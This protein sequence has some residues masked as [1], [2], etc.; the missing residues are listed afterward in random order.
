MLDEIADLLVGSRCPGCRE[1]GLG[2]CR[3]CREGLPARPRLVSGPLP[4]AAAGD[5]GPLERA[6]VT[7]HKDGGAWYLARPLG[8]LLAAAVSLLLDE[9][10][11]WPV[12]GAAPVTLVPVP[13]SPASVRE[14]GYDHGRALAARAARRLGPGVGVRPVL[15]RSQPVNDQ[16]R[17][18]RRARALNQRGSLSARP[19]QGLVVVTDDLCTTGASLAEAVR[20]LRAGGWTVLGGA[21]VSHPRRRVRLAERQK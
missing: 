4:L 2:L 17:L 20:A 15:R 10:S 16:S 11:Q 6:L 18:D 5:Y 3:R 1:P 9:T 14:R 19:G 8:D 12:A 7:A 21:V 13:S